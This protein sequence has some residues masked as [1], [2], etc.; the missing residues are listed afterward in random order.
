MADKQYVAIATL[1]TGEVQ[2]VDYR[3]PEGQ[4]H[5]ILRKAGDNTRIAVSLGDIVA[6]LGH[7]D[8]LKVSRVRNA[9]IYAGR[10]VGGS[11]DV[12][13][14][15]DSHDV[16]V[17]ISEA[18]VTGSYLATI[19]GGCSNAELFIQKRTGHG[20]EVDIDLGNWFDYNRRKTTNTKLSCPNGNGPTTCRIL[21]SDDPK[22]APNQS[23][24]VYKPWWRKLF[25]AFYPILKKLGIA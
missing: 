8:A 2:L 4:T 15:T 20:S 10:V 23:W 1:P 14:I 12:I 19:K 16:A 24:K 11:E 18:V 9:D 25:L 22:I 6:P 21:D 17:S 5:T 7:Q 3:A 13:D